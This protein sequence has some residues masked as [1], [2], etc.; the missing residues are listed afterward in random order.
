MTGVAPRP[1]HLTCWIRSITPSD[2]SKR[3]SRLFEV[4]R[5]RV[6]SP[7]ISLLARPD[8]LQFPYREPDRR[9]ASTLPIRPTDRANPRR[10]PSHR[11]K[12]IPRNAKSCR[13]ARPSWCLLR[14][15]MRIRKLLRPVD[16]PG[17][18]LPCLRPIPPGQYCE[19]FRNR[20]PCHP[21]RKRRCENRLANQVSS[22]PWDWL[23]RMGDR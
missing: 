14:L 11:Q 18:T 8:V 21:A 1:T 2:R 6:L 7:R 3:P 10:T 22:R 17:R 23:T 12:P 4:I 16:L 13:A 5:L 19:R 9:P 15:T 20:Q